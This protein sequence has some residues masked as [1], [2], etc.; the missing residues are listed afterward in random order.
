VLLVVGLYVCVMKVKKP[1]K[2]D[3]PLPSSNAQST[4]F[5]RRNQIAAS[6]SDAQDDSLHNGQQGI[7]SKDCDL[8][9]FD[10]E[11]IRAAT[12]NFSIHNKIGQGG[13]GPVYMVRVARV[14]VWREPEYMQR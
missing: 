5:R 7:N 11:K 1:R 14:S 12:D 10:V 3:T 8:P 13:F 2:E 6:G 4:P 9:S